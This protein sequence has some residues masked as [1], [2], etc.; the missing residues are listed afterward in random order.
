MNEKSRYK[1]SISNIKTKT[2]KWL[3][4][5]FSVKRQIILYFTAIGK[6]PIIL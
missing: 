4:K 2:K 5:F 1:K 3:N 6:T